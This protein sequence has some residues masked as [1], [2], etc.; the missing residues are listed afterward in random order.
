M[1]NKA[2]FLDRDGVLNHAIIINGLPYAPASVN[3]LTIPD[4]ARAAL[5]KLKK[6]NFLLI[7]VTNQPD[8]A[9]GKTPL[10]AV[11]EI[12]HKMQQLL[13][14]DDFFVCFHDDKDNCHC[15]KPL[16]G[17]LL[18]AAR[19]YTIDLK[20]SFMVGDR[21]KDMAAGEAA[22]CKTIWMK[23]DYMEKSPIN[24]PDFIAES[25]SEVAAFVIMGKK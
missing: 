12:N 21:W 17:L 8:V 19:K 7:V 22:G 24:P 13:P 4:G 6:A 25:L 16:P 11:E 23:Q 9:R 20:S 14:V 3:E 2:V 18:D 1:L 15:R 10:S 5:E